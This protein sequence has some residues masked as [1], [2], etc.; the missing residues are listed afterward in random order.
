VF[1]AANDLIIA[2]ALVLWGQ[3]FN[4]V[5]EAAHDYERYEYRKLDLENSEDN[6][7]FEGALAW[8]LGI[9]DKKRQD[10]K[11]LRGRKEVGLL[12][13]HD[14]HVSRCYSVNSFTRL[15]Y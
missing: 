6:A 14:S 11:S 15:R 7:F 2:G 10:G 13:P 1:G 12:Y 5:V 4:P 3:D 9:D 8:D